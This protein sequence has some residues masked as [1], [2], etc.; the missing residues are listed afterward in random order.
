MKRRNSK[1]KK[2]S[3]VKLTSAGITVL[4]IVAFVS[5]LMYWNLDSKCKG[6]SREIANGEKKFAAL[7]SECV[8]EGVRWE[9]MKSKD[10]FAERLIR[11][12]IEMPLQNQYQVVR[13][14]NGRPMNGFAVAKVKERS[15]A[16]AVAQVAQVSQVKPATPSVRRAVP[17]GM[18]ASSG[19]ATRRRV[20]RR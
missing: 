13:M 12:G 7:E 14:R 4:V 16:S 5:M 17:A 2:D 6:V 3:N 8:R 10:H 20:A 15:R 18:A 9:K 11:A 1:I 19:V